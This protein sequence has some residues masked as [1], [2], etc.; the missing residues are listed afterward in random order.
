MLT[1]CLSV[2]GSDTR[3]TESWREWFQD[4]AT[5]ESLPRDSKEFERLAKSLRAIA[6]VHERA[7]LK[8][9][10]IVQK[11]RARTILY[12]LQRL[13]NLPPHPA[14]E[15]EVIL[16]WLPHEAWYATRAL[17]PGLYKVVTAVAALDET[18][19]LDAERAA[20][21]ESLFEEERKK[22]E[23]D[24]AERLAAGLYRRA[25]DA[26]NVERLAQVHVWRG[27]DDA[28]RNLL[29]EAIE[30]SVDAA[31]AVR[32]RLARARVARAAGD[33]RN[34]LADFGAALVCGSDDAAL[35]LGWIALHAGER[36]RALQ[37]AQLALSGATPSDPALTL[38]GLAQLPALDEAQRWARENATLEAPPAPPTPT[39]PRRNPTPRGD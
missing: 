39:P 38:Y 1:A 11:Y 32:L 26:P 28:A 19:A 13:Q 7:G 29:T 23:F 18:P 17:R 2:Q 33:E 4:L 12:H 37:L 14:T 31:S 36:K 3:P 16:E 24:L 5:L 35:D 34:A 8:A 21:A 27:N 10:N 6:V 15:P 20:W 25:P 30:A 22:L 9:R